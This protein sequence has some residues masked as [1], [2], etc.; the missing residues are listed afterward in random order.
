MEK[1]TAEEAEVLLAEYGTIRRDRDTRVLAA[2]AA[3][4]PIAR[5]AALMGIGVSTVERIIA[6]HP[7]DG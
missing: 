5:I 6:R 1:I 2:R 3:R 4:L 7:A